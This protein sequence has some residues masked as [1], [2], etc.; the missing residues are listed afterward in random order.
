MM[1]L[2]MD[3]G[4]KMFNELLDRVKVTIGV[5]EVKVLAWIQNRKRSLH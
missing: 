5:N 4:M 2:E 3:K 1:S